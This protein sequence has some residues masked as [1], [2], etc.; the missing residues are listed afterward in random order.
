MHIIYSFPWYFSDIP[1]TD[2][3]YH[4]PI[5]NYAYFF[6]PGTTT[7]TDNATYYRNIGRDECNNGFQEFKVMQDT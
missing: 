2:Y 7:L 4:L 3:T 1:L 5:N 6:C